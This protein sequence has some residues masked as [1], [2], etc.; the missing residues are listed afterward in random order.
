MQVQYSD[1]AVFPDRGP[2]PGGIPGHEAAGLFVASLG[3]D[4]D[5]SYDGG[6]EVEQAADGVDDAGPVVHGV[7]PLRMAGWPAG[8]P[9]MVS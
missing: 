4:G 6:G 3:P 5:E 8:P 1:A 9:W 2:E 7:F